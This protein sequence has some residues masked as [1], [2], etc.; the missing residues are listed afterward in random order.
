VGWYVMGCNERS[1][2]VRNAEWSHREAKWQTP[3]DISS[4]I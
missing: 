2:L 1:T 3:W 4:L